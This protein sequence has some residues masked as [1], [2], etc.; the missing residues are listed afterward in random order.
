VI[1]NSKQ[2]KLVV[3]I[4]EWRVWSKVRRKVNH[5]QRHFDQCAEPAANVLRINAEPLQVHNYDVW[6]TPDLLLHGPKLS[7][8]QHLLHCVV[9]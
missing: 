4:L 2:P 5:T 8:S 9:L 7:S 1:R 3:V 6:R